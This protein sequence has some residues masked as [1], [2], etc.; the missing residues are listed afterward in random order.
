[1][2]HE[3]AE[4]KAIE[5][6][7]RT[8]QVGEVQLHVLE[9]GNAKGD[10]LLV[11][12]PAGGA[13]RWYPYHA[14]LATHHRIIAPDHPGFGRTPATD[15]IDR[16]EDIAFL[17]SRFLDQL[18]L[19]KISVLG[20]SFGGWIAAELAV[21]DPHRIDRLVLVNSIGLRI[22]D[23]PIADLFLM[24]PQQKA[25]GLFHDQ[26]AAARLFAGPPDIDTIMGFFHDETAFARYAWQPFCCNPRLATRLWR[27]K[28]PTLVLLGDRDQIV[29]RAHGEFYSKHIA[30][31][32]LK[33]IPNAGHALLLEGLDDG[34][35]AIEQFWA[36]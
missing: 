30:N 7:S 25:Q 17:Y 18:G 15:D 33:I 21:L 6:V 2:G 16:V 9:G 13:S 31:A 10:P 36:S 11:L 27:I 23:H 4:T 1:M 29:P 26:Q 32:R 12:H 19:K 35:A 14:E 3:S 34:V 22:P 5:G 20:L 28:S 24:S 8:V